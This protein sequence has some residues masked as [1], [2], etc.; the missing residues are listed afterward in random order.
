VLLVTMPEVTTAV[1][2]KIAKVIPALSLP[3]V[4]VIAVEATVVLW[5]RADRHPPKR[6]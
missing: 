1:A 5:R 4:I 3:L 2:T 6:R